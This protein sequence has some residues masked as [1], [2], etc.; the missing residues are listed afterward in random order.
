[1]TYEPGDEV[2]ILDTS[3]NNR[4]QAYVRQVEGERVQVWV[5]RFESLMWFV[6]GTTTRGRFKLES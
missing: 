3:N 5:R 6:R 1:M 2:V 4:L